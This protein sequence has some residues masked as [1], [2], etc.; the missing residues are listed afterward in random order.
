MNLL[1]EVFAA[2]VYPALGCTEPVS[3]AFAAATASAHLE[4]PVEELMLR[5]DPGTYKNGAAVTV[6]HSDGATGNLIAAALGAV[7]A[8]PEGKLEL[9]RDVTPEMLVEAKHLC[10]DG[11]CRYECFEDTTELRIEVELAGRRHRVRS[12]VA[13][14]HTNVV[15]IEKDG[16]RIVD[17]EHD[18]A[19]AGSLAYRTALKEANLRQLLSLVGALGDD[20]RA[21]VQYG[22]DMNLAMARRG[23]EVRGTACQLRR[24]HQRGYLAEDLFYRTKLL[25]ASA[26]DARMAGVSEPVMTSGGS[27][28]QGIVAILTPYEVGR[29][30]G[31][32]QRHII[33][34]IAAAHL[35]NAYCKCFVGE[36]SVICGCA[37][38]AGIAAAVAI[39]YQQA[40]IDNDRITL[41][42]NNVIGDLGGLIC[43]G[44]KPGCAMKTITAVDTAIRSG[45]MA[46]EGFGLS[47]ADGMVGTTAEDSIRNLGRV[48]L[49]GMLSVDP[50]VLR[51]LR[52]KDARR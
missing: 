39:V 36:L 1:D 7:V 25:V 29:E 49:E 48:T 15:L 38:A 5:V 22:I 30:T 35:V 44:A 50:T 18:A 40:G 19:R 41:A 26:V 21:Y 9:L 8:R 23:Y 4:E 43:D 28:N 31:V 20:N 17:R 37:M 24:I 14:S 33:E 51:I 47:P 27:G 45:L 10:R 32:D 46:V 3:C 42:V 2:E 11:R 12:A 13:G 6:P 34:S 52:E 16:R